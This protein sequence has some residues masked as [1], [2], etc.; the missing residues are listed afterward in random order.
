MTPAAIPAIVL[1]VKTDR[2]VLAKLLVVLLAALRTDLPARELDHVARP[3]K[4]CIE[5][6]SKQVLGHQRCV[7]LELYHYVTVHL[8]LA[9]EL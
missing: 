3:N 2:E 8:Q 5:G 9:R 1:K 4:S 6:Y 7:V